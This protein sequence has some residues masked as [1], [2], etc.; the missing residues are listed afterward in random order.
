MTLRACVSAV[1]CQEAD[2][3][4]TFRDRERRP[5]LSSDRVHGGEHCLGRGEVCV[6]GG[7]LA[8]GYYTEEALTKKAFDEDGY[9]YSERLCS[10]TVA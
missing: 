3:S 9:T 6:K 10:D 2:G 5:Y 7:N 4:F 1:F 8:S